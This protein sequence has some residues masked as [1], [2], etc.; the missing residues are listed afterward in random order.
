MLSFFYFNDIYLNY[1]IRCSTRILAINCLRIL[2][3]TC[4]KLAKKAN[5]LNSSESDLNDAAHLNLTKARNIKS[6]S[7]ATN[8][9]DFLIFYLSDL[10][11]ISFMSTTSDHVGLQFCGLQLMQDIIKHFSTVPDPDSP[12][13][14]FGGL[15]LIFF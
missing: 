11:R 3:S 6:S 15:K 1:L 4:V 7:T 13:W 8:R 9:S 14:S 12:G 10:V 2:I 5:R